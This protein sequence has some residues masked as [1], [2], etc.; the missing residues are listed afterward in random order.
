MARTAEPNQSHNAGMRILLVAD[1]KA[2]S[3]A[4]VDACATKHRSDAC[5]FALVVPAMLHEI[6]WV[7]DPYANRP[8]ARRALAEID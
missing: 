8:S 3:Q 6:D 2:E 1:W 7:G 5:S 4:V